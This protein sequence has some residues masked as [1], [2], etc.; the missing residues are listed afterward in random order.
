MPGRVRRRKAPAVRRQDVPT[1]A[2][3]RWD[4]DA[5]IT[6]ERLARLSGGPHRMTDE[7]LADLM[8]ERQAED[9]AAFEARRRAEG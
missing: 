1:D 8:A 3:A 5:A 6:R 9:D 2:Q 7:R 4:R